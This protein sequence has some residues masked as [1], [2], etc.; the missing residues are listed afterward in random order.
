MKDLPSV[1]RL[2][3]FYLLVL[4]DLL[5]CKMMVMLDGKCFTNGPASES[6]VAIWAPYLLFCFDILLVEP[7][8]CHPQARVPRV[9]LPHR[10]LRFVWSHGKKQGLPSWLHS[11]NNNNKTHLPVQET[12]RHGFNPWVRKNPW[13]RK[14]QP[15]PVF[16][17]GESHRQ[18]RSVEATVFRITKNRT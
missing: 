10:G 11:K 3:P 14:W 6:K 15:T 18:K 13:R 1:L 17:P 7:S 2:Y 4:E 12:Q 5:F 8:G 16:L 9:G